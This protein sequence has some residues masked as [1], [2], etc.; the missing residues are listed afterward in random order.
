MYEESI[1]LYRQERK[2][3]EKLLTDLL[4]KQVIRQMKKVFVFLY[5]RILQS[6]LSLK[7]LITSTKLHFSIVIDI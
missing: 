5:F 3:T 7:Y 6:V 2:K 1:N 4:P